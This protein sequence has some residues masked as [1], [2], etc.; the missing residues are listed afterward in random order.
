MDQNTQGEKLVTTLPQNELAL[1]VLRDS[2]IQILFEK[3][4]RPN[5]ESTARHTDQGLVVD[6]V[7]TKDNTK[8]SMVVSGKGHAEQSLHGFH[9]DDQWKGD[10]TIT[11][12]DGGKRSVETAKFDYSGSMLDNLFR[13]YDRANITLQRSTADGKPI[14]TYAPAISDYV[15]DGKT[16]VRDPN[17]QPLRHA[18]LAN[19]EVNCE[20]D[21]SSRSGK[22]ECSWLIQ[23][24]RLHGDISAN[25]TNEQWGAGNR[26]HTVL[27]TPDG[28][29]LGIVDQYIK[30]NAEGELTQVTTQAKRPENYK[31]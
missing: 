1:T 23:D 20:K 31:P 4:V 28:K 7:N 26:Y 13:R 11:R 27:R 12:Q 21:M 6:T 14:Q 3:N 10:F 25:M 5:L 19:G 15:Y 17:G 24:Q 22:Y 9:T 2:A 29:V 30:R 16:L 18:R 8:S